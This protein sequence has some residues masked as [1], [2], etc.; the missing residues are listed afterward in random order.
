MQ[1]YMLNSLMTK[2]G[3][4]DFNKIFQ[5]CSHDKW[6]QPN[7]KP[8]SLTT[9][10]FLNHYIIKGFFF[11]FYTYTFSLYLN[12]LDVSLLFEFY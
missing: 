3:F 5:V 1:C 7:F 12:I 11:F 4:R 6:L 8:S 10:H 2:L 9:I